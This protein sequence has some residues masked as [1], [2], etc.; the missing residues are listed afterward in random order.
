[1]NE[2]KIELVYR[3]EDEANPSLLMAAVSRDELWEWALVM[4]FAVKEATDSGMEEHFKE[5]LRGVTDLIEAC[6]EKGQGR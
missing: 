3:A 2:P 5:Q 4:E 6:D 1:M